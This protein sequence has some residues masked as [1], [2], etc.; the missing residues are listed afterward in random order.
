M[1][2]KRIQLSLFVDESA[3][4]SIESI[5]ATF[6]PAQYVLIPA[7]VTLCR[8]DEL[9]QIDQVIQNLQRLNQDSITIDFG[10]VIR[11]SEGKGVLIPAIGPNE[12]FQQ[13]RANILQGIIENPRLPEPHITLM[14]PRN[15]TC[16]DEIF[17]QIAQYSLPRKITFKKIS[18]IEQEIGMKWCI[19]DEFH[20]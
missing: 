3:S 20:L 13:L 16:T 14:H 1:P 2:Q 18:L 15:A 17:A 6:N 4:S 19:L 5:R 8:E 11:F 10:P 12:S 9:E 7:H